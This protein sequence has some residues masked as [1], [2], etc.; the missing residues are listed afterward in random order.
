MTGLVIEVPS[1]LKC[2]SSYRHVALTVAL[3]ALKVEMR[4]QR[5]TER[6]GEKEVRTEKRGKSGDA[7]E[8]SVS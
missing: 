5:D 4:L 1:N 6:S 2:I 7:N 3:A 8:L